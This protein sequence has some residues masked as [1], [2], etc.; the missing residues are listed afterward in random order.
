VTETAP[1]LDYTLKENRFYLA[2][3]TTQHYFWIRNESFHLWQEVA[4]EAAKLHSCFL[5]CS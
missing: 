2:Y 1:Q 3:K 4:L 5:W